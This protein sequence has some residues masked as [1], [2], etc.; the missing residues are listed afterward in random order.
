[1]NSLGCKENQKAF[2][3]VRK[4]VDLGLLPLRVISKK[5]EPIYKGKPVSEKS[6]EI[7]TQSGLEQIGLLN[8]V[9]LKTPLIISNNLVLKAVG[10]IYRKSKA[11]QRRLKR[12]YMRA[13]IKAGRGR[14]DGLNCKS[15]RLEKKPQYLKR[16]TKVA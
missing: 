9:S 15:R 7:V 8:P 4:Q 11:K 16:Y 1:M 14:T 12:I 3:S 5:R 2:K 6:D 10:Y 13:W